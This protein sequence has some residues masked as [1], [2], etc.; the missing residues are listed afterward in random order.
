[1]EEG[2]EDSLTQLV[3]SHR[4]KLGACTR[5]MNEIKELCKTKME[6]QTM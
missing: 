2:E 4:G 3:G 5:K 6:V 1:M